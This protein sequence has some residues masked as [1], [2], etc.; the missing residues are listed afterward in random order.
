[1]ALAPAIDVFEVR[2]GEA[3]HDSDAGWRR[4][5]RLRCRPLH[6]TA[7][8]IQLHRQ[9]NRSAASFRS[10]SGGAVRGP[11]GGYRLQGGSHQPFNFRDRAGK[12]ALHWLWNLRR[13]HKIREILPAPSQRGR[14]LLAA[15]G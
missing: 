2:Q 7:G 5:G 9:Q 10:A 12:A 13:T 14:V 4:R 8:Y 6:C 3:D 1:M 15:P 11:S